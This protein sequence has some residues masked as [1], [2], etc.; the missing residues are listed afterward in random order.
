MIAALYV[1][2]NGCYFDL[3]GVDPWD[4]ER[5]ARQYPGPHRAR[6]ATWLYAVRVELP[7]L[8]WGSSQPPEA[9]QMDQGFHSAEE[10]RMFMRPPKDMTS[11]WR[12]KRNRWLER[13]EAAGFKL[14]CAPERMGSKERLATPEPFRDLLIGIAESVSG[15]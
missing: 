8:R 2:T 9:K 12:A 3:E 13:R 6:K 14:N 7:S 10:R 1:E 4:E 15:G 5:D 11:E